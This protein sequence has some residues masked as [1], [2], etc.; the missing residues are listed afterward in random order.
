[1][2]TLGLVLAYFCMGFAEWNI[3]TRRT[4]CISQ[5]RA[6]KASLLALIE[7]ALGA[8]VFVYIVF[9]KDQWWLLA[10]GVLGGAVGVYLGVRRSK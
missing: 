4:W 8:F 6:W 9:N 2:K 3:A 5:R 10:F 1:M 7:E